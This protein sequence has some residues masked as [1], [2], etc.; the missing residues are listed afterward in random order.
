M[1]RDIWW[2]VMAKMTIDDIIFVV[3]LGLLGFFLGSA[4]A[5]TVCKVKKLN[6]NS[7]RKYLVWSVWPGLGLLWF[8]NYGSL[9]SETI[10]K[11]GIG[12]V[13]LF[14]LRGFSYYYSR[15]KWNI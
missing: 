8:C 15:F 14:L 9:T 4:A 12:A 1:I 6:M 2:Y 7:A 10:L 11:I 3:S 13:I 5:L